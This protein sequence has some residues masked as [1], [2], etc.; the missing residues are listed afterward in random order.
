ME[1]SSWN[2]G[3]IHSEDIATP[4]VIGF[5]TDNRKALH[6]QGIPRLGTI[7]HKKLVPS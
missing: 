7:E 5:K 6:G 2:A 1:N 3:K 4:S